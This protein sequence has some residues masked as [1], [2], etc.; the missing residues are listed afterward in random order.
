MPLTQAHFAAAPSWRERAGGSTVIDV[1]F[2]HLAHHSPEYVRGG[3][4]QGGR[5]RTS[6]SSR[7]HGCIRSSRTCC[8]SG[9]SSS[10]MT[11]RT[12]RA[13]SALR[14]ARRDDPF[15]AR[16]ATHVA[17]HRARSV[18]A[19]PISCSTCSHEDRVLVQRA[20]RHPIRQD[21]SSCRTARSPSAVAPSGSARRAAL[22]RDG[23]ELPAGPAAVFVAHASTRQTSRR[24]DSSSRRLRPRCRSVTFVI[25]GGV[26]EAFAGE[27]LP[28]N[29]RSDG[30]LRRGRR[31]ADTSKRPTSPSIRCSPVRARTSRCSTSWPPACRLSR[32][33]S[34]LVAFGRRPSR[35]SRSRR[36]VCRRRSGASSP[37]AGDRVDG[38]RRARVARQKY[39]WERL[40]PVSGDCS[41]GIE[42]ACAAAAGGERHRATYER[43]DVLGRCRVPRA[44]DLPRVRSDRRRSER[45]PVEGAEVPRSPVCSHRRGNAGHARNLGAFYARGD[46]LAFTDDDCRPDATGWSGPAL[47]RG[48]RH[49]GRRRQC[50]VGSRARRAVPSRD[51]RRVRRHR[52]HD[53]EPVPAARDLQ[54]IDGFDGQFDH[55]HSARTPI[56]AGGHSITAPFP[57]P[58]TCG[59]ITRRSRAPSPARGLPRGSGSSRRTR[60]CSRSIRSGIARCSCAKSCAHEGFAE[61]VRG[62]QVQRRLDELPDARRRQSAKR[63]RTIESMRTQP[64]RELAKA[65]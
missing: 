24:R 52:L 19:R 1:A 64:L 2:P 61:P 38:R 28:A 9:R 32:P 22:K 23:A 25:C 5:A 53:R 10:S 15:G 13:C 57:S 30:T 47:F 35:R 54:R 44:A 55:P 34:V 41:I 33:R 46:V 8:D 49:R 63:S 17:A 50:P 65:P 39:S 59:S 6:S 11:R 21:A 26:G 58:L 56:S 18:H 60:C 14:A 51:E 29:V 45:A 12:S 31:S 3:A 48:S 43:H 27:S 20:L 4:P 62:R 42:H 7:I 36:G 40:S 16:I 37:T